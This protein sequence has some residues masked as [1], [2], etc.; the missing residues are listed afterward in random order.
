MGKKQQQTNSDSLSRQRK[1]SSAKQDNRLIWH[2]TKDD[3]I[4]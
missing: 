2:D 1:V 4:D 3:F